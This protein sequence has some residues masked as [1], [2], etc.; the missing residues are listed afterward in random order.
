MQSPLS[1]VATLHVVRGSAC[2]QQKEMG[3]VQH[4]RHSAYPQP[5][6]CRSSDNLREGKIMAAQK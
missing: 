3:I 2:N 4:A 1:E 6:K 5:S